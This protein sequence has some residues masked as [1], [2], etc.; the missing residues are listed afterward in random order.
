MDLQQEFD[1][2]IKESLFYCE[3]EHF[4]QNRKDEKYYD[5]EYAKPIISF[6]RKEEPNL[7]RYDLIRNPNA[8]PSALLHPVQDYAICIWGKII[9]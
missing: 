6:L 8:L 7:L 2:A 1:L 3:E 5:D 4:N 9:V